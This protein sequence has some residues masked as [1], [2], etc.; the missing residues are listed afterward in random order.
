MTSTPRPS[1]RYIVGIDLGTTNI[2]LSYVDL[3]GEG[4]L[5]LAVRDLPI[6]QLVA[7]GE[8]GDRPLLPSNLYL[9]T[10][11]EKGA[12]LLRLPWGEEAH[13]VGALAVLRGAQVPSRLISSA[14]SWLCHGGVDRTA[15][16]LPWG[17]ESSVE[18]LSPVDVSAR[19]LC[20]LAAVWGRAF[21]DAPLAEQEIVLTVP[22]SFDEVARELTVAAAR[23][24]GLDRLT[25]IEEPQAA[26]YDWTRRHR[27]RLDRALGDNRL[28]LVVDVGGGTTDLTLISAESGETGPRLRRVSVGR[29]LLLGG[30]NMDAT[31]ARHIEARLG[32]R[33]DATRWS[34]LVHSCKAAKEALLSP[35]GPDEAVVSVLERG[36]RLIGASQSVALRRHELVDLLREGFFPRVSRQERPRRDRRVGLQ[37]VSLPY[38]V[39]PAITR[40]VAAFLSDH[41]EEVAPGSDF[42][43]PDAVLLNGGVF[44]SPDLGERLVEVIDA[45]GGQDRAR[46]LNL[47]S[48]DAL[49][50][51]VSRGAVCFGLVRRGIG[52]RIGGGSARAY[53]IGLSKS[54]AS[55][56]TGEQGARGICLVPRH[57]EEGSEVCLPQRFELLLD[58]PARFSLFASTLALSARP[59]DIVSMEGD[60][61]TALSPIE[62][63]LRSDKAPA[64]KAQATQ[65]MRVPVRLKAALTEIGTLELWC[66][67]CDGDARW[68][69]EFSLRGETGGPKES[70]PSAVA[71]MPR[72]FDKARERVEIIYGK[73][74]APVDKRD[75]KGLTRELE[76]LLGPK[77]GWTTPVIREL[78]GALYAGMGKRRRSADHERLWCALVGFCLRPGFGAPLDSWRAAET[79]RVFE[80]GL[81]F[82][83]EAHNWEAWWVMWRRVSGGLDA[84]AQKAIL[85][86]VLPAIRPERASGKAG[87]PK[88]ARAEGVVEMIRL[89][90]SL[91]RVEVSQKIQLGEAIF[92]RIADEGALPHLLW[93]LGRIGA[94]VPFHGSAHT[95]VDAPVASQWVSRLMALKG[96]KPQDLAFAVAQ[97]ARVSGDRGR[98]LDEET[99]LETAQFLERLGA[100]AGMAQSVRE[101][102][103]LTGQDEER[104]FGESLPAGLT[105]VESP[106]TPSAMRRESMTPGAGN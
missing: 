89:A 43:M 25:L 54:D 34:A 56:E 95:C 3:M 58:R 92:D 4:D 42:A 94:R 100:A 11:G 23:A 52:L 78:W 28:V 64:K 68:K 33:L 39:D 22:A 85:E 103:A 51:A 35:T 21:P 75:V 27:G 87:K 36:S 86:A 82:Q 63:V 37:E 7:P 38:E 69:L 106:Q 70:L 46:R 5:A 41:A 45:W 65:E 99:R 73:K 72:H 93:S 8:V 18:R 57:L 77:E 59:G 14:K 32:K 1:A 6:T 84:Q 83:K 15:A 79:F 26:F 67:A 98:D 20:H 12:G 88:A 9:P 13:V 91:E 30:D 48:N 17:A 102:M 81:Q 19:Y 61:F 2:A 101:F 29:H 16:I 47:L 71:P 76:K 62:T 10:E 31:I 74:P 50:L 96:A 55:G 60:E 44:A 24:A 104:R 53:F 49:D 40:H 80:Q 97:I 90:A 66:E 105:L